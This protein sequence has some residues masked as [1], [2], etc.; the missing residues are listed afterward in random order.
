M[1]ADSEDKQNEIFEEDSFIAQLLGGKNSHNELDDFLGSESTNLFEFNDTHRS[2]ISRSAIIGNN[3]LSAILEENSGEVALANNNEVTFIVHTDGNGE[4]HENM[5]PELV[6]LIADDQRVSP[7]Q[8]VTANSSTYNNQR[9]QSYFESQDQFFGEKGDDKRQEIDNLDFDELSDIDSFA[10]Q[11]FSMNRA[12]DPPLSPIFSREV[13]SNMLLDEFIMP[14]PGKTPNPN[15]LKTRD[16]PISNYSSPLSTK[17]FGS[18]ASVQTTNQY[19]EEKNEVEESNSIEL[20][21]DFNPQFFDQAYNHSPERKTS[22]VPASQETSY[23]PKT[24]SANNSKPFSPANKVNV[25]KPSMIPQPSPRKRTSSTELSSMGNEKQLRKSSWGNLNKPTTSGTNPV[26]KANSLLQKMTPLRWSPI[27]TDNTTSASN[28]KPKPLGNNSTTRSKPS[29]KPEAVKTNVSPKKGAFDFHQFKS[30]LESTHN[31]SKQ[32]TSPKYPKQAPPKDLKESEN[33]DPANSSFRFDPSLLE[34]SPFN[35]GSKAPSLA[36]FD[37]KSTTHS[38]FGEIKEVFAIDS[39]P[40]NAP[41]SLPSKKF[42]SGRVRQIIPDSQLQK[43]A[44]AV[45][46]KPPV[47]ESHNQGAEKFNSFSLST[48]SSLNSDSGSGVLVNVAKM[49]K[50]MH[51]LATEQKSTFMLLEDDFDED[52]G[53]NIDDESFSACVDISQ[54][55]EEDNRG[56]DL[57]DSD[58]SDDEILPPKWDK[59]PILEMLDQKQELFSSPSTYFGMKSGKLGDLE[60]RAA[61]EERPHF[62]TPTTDDQGHVLVDTMPETPIGESAAKVLFRPTPSTNP[63]EEVISENILP[64]EIFIPQQLFYEAIPPP[65]PMPL[66]QNEH[67]L[68]LPTPISLQTKRTIT[69]PTTKCGH[70]V[71]ITLRIENNYTR[72]TKFTLTP[73]GKCYV[74][75]PNFGRAHAMDKSLFVFEKTT[76]KLGPGEYSIFIAKVK[77]LMVGFYAQKWHLKSFDKVAVLEFEMNVEMKKSGVVNNVNI[78]SSNYGKVAGLSGK[79]VVRQKVEPPRKRLPTKAVVNT[80]LRRG[81]ERIAK[82]PPVQRQIKPRASERC[83]YLT[84]DVTNP[85]P[86]TM[87]VLEFSNVHYGQTVTKSIW[88]VSTSMSP[89]FVNVIG[90]GSFCPVEKSLRVLPMGKEEIKVMFKGVKEGEHKEK[91]IVKHGLTNVKADMQANVVVLR[92]KRSLIK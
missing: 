55:M 66:Y 68:S 52:F 22:K 67:A 42:Q 33:F 53:M 58:S 27:R 61:L 16:K 73:V 51:A 65:E 62:K 28:T 4:N 56:E 29:S 14:S 79:K 5:P 44:Q 26:S 40:S 85:P 75:G 64:N 23:R 91:L 83:M 60:G 7:N 15:R 20:D 63:Q 13:E 48:V 74:T 87:P 84:K 59:S 88:L 17:Y 30:A 69:F 10:E 31:N 24:L 90:G 3:Q 57:S 1:L 86:I 81:P 46:F 70:T 43:M 45:G 35:F 71:T 50:E 49:K 25:V 39:K 54:R 78:S 80:G 47:R 6:E 19:V 77:P 37:N 36:P 18:E 38:K 2:S 11:S 41:I 89:L 76:E 9:D 92:R 82:K 12:P 34:N 32:T 8:N 72:A 21:L